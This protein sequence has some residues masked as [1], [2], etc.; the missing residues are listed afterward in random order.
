MSQNGQEDQNLP[1]SLL[2][3]VLPLPIQ[4]YTSVIYSRKA[5][6]RTHDLVTT[7][8]LPNVAVHAQ[9]SAERL[10]ACHD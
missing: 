2:I 1:S 8:S 6:G 10:T 7:E 4:Q 3:I 9:I 5:A